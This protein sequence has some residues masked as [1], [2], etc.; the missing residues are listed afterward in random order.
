MVPVPE[1]R[2]RDRDVRGGSQ[3]GGWGELA[4]LEAAGSGDE[5]ERG[6][7]GELG[8]HG[9]VDQGLRLVGRK[10]LEVRL[11]DALREQVVVI[12]RQAHH[13]QDLARL[14]VHAC[15]LA[16]RVRP[17][18]IGAFSLASLLLIVK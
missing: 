1:L 12:G 6:P 7:R 2:S 14:R 15:D 13:G 5:L 3:L 8:L 18:V 17:V 16:A 10:L 9:I 11:R 4:V